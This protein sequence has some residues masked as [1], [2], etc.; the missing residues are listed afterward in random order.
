M[1]YK[2]HGIVVGV[3]N[4]GEADKSVA[5]FRLLPLVVVVLKVRLPLHCSSFLC[6]NSIL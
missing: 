2:A 1:A 5:G 6:S 3:K 4:W